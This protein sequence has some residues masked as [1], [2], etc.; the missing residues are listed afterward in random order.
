MTR[1]GADRS[2]EVDRRVEWE[3]IRTHPPHSPASAW[4]GTHV[5]FDIARRAAP[6]WATERVDTAVLDFRHSWD[7]RSE[8]LGF[9]NFHWGEA[10][11]KLKRWCESP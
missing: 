5:A 10:L 11:R 7:E 9:C 6:P 4:T 1:M 2:G 8:Y 3:F